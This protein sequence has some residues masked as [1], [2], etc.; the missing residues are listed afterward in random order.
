MKP[1]IKI[2]EA[3]LQKTFRRYR[4]VSKRGLAED[5]NQKSYSIL[6]KAAAQNKTADRAKIQDELG[7]QATAIRGQRIKI[8]KDG[9]IQRGKLITERIYGE[10]LYAIVRAKFAKQG[11]TISAG[12]LESTAKRELSRRMSAI[13]FMKSGWFAALAPIAKAIGKSLKAK[14]SQKAFGGATAA[15]PDS[16]KPASL[17]FNTSF[18]KPE[19]TTDKQPTRWALQAL[20]KAFSQEAADMRQYIAK[21]MQARLKRAG[22]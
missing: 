14:R 1:S 3:E 18:N 4:E 2:N 10:R 6:I 13:N 22:R 20:A 12:E 11:R 7:Q 5:I 9:T 8:R 21:K 17:F 19:N 16:F 15:K